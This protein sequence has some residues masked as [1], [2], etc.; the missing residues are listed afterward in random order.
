ML[1][2]ACS[3]YFRDLFKENPC[4]HPVIISRDVKFDDLVALVD[5]MYHGEV[6]VVREQ[7]SS[8]L[9]TAEITPL[10]LVSAVTTTLYTFI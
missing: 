8:F 6:N 2:S 5:F 4:Q 3:T 10:P 9:T 1:L 7:L